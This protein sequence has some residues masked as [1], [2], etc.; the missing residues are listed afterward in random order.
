MKLTEVDPAGWLE[1]QGERTSE[2]GQSTSWGPH[3]GPFSDTSHQGSWDPLAL[4]LMWLLA[5]GL[6][7]VTLMEIELKAPM[8]PAAGVRPLPCLR[9]CVAAAAAA[10]SGFCSLGT[11]GSPCV[12]DPPP[13]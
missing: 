7:G 12:P 3:T 10:C 6:M 9:S 2:E 8:D 5:R 4:P 13:G 1:G 11:R